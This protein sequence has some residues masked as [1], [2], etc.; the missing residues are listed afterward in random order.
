MYGAEAVILALLERAAGADASEVQLGVFHHAGQAEPEVYTRAR[1]ASLSADL[2]LCEGQFDAAVPTRIRTL[3]TASGVDAIHAHGYKA[4]IYSWAAFAGRRRPA[5]VSTCHTWYDNDLAVR[6]YG[7]LDRLVLRG[8]DEVVAVSGEV[9]ARLLAAGVAPDCVHL[10]RNGLNTAPFVQASGRRA[11]ANERPLRVGFA[12]RLAPEKGVE[13]FLRAVAELAPGLP[14]AEF[15][16]AGD[17]PDRAALEHLA[18][19]LRVQDRVHFAGRPASMPVYYASLDVLVSASRQEGLPMVLLEAMASGLPVVATRVGEVPNVVLNGQTG[20]LVEP[21]QPRALAAAVFLLL[22]DAM[23]RQRMGAAG[24][25]RAVAEFSV[26]RMASDYEAVYRRAVRRRAR[27][28]S[29]AG[30]RLSA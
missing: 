25:A 15:V 10:I 5:L 29:G 19:Q 3:A 2:I 30:D 8:L 11:G 26:E 13:V 7:A 12:G 18:K 22:R 14:D 9:E 4:D 17:G 27:A 20:L 6:L 1:A 28:G 16:I 24:Q 21:D 23:L